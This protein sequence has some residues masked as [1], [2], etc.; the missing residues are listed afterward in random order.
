MTLRKVELMEGV[1]EQLDKGLPSVA[2][3]QWIEE[4]KQLDIEIMIRTKQ[5]RAMLIAGRMWEKGEMG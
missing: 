4:E 2:R 5:Y 1:M 3:Q